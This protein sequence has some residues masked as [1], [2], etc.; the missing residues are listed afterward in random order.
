MLEEGG[1]P[2]RMITGLDSLHTTIQSP[3]AGEEIG[4]GPLYWIERGT[5]LF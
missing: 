3:I 5:H 2:H 4:E 1:E